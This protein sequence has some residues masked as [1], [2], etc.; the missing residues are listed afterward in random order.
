MWIRSQ[1]RKILVNVNNIFIE[2]P[3]TMTLLDDTPFVDIVGD[4]YTLGLYTEKRVLEVLD[5]IQENISVLEH[6]KVYKS[7]KEEMYIQ[8]RYIYEMPEK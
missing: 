8:G 5:D 7:R 6:D 3:S 4:G 2:E 1:N